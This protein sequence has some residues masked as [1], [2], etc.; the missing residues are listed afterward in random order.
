MFPLPTAYRQVIKAPPCRERLYPSRNLRK[1]SN[2]TNPPCQGHG[3]GRLT[4]LGMFVA[5]PPVQS[6]PACRAAIA[7]ARSGLLGFPPVT[8][9]GY[10]PIPPHRRPFLCSPVSF[11]AS[12]PLLHLTFRPIHSFCCRV[13]LSFPPNP[14]RPHGTS[15]PFNPTQS[16]PPTQTDH[17]TDSLG[18][19]EVFLSLFHSRKSTNSQFEPHRYP[20]PISHH[21][22]QAHRRRRPRGLRHGC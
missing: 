9:S 5:T 12:F 21:E 4:E 8:R 1:K 2:P 7:S 17:S 13:F 11:L 20:S 6:R 19:S 18:V 15:S 3:P 16:C 14:L 22:V 10:S